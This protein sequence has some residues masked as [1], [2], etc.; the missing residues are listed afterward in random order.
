[1]AP[2]EV[3][4]RRTPR[5]GFTVAEDGGYLVGLTTE[6]TPQLELEGQARELVRR[7]QQLRK[8][9]GLEI[10]DRIRLGLPDL[11]LAA[12]LMSSHRDYV[13]SETLT[14]EVASVTET[15]S[16]PG[17]ASVTFSLG[18][19]EVTIALTVAR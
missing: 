15:L 5:T 12:A 1:M 7:I 8:D 16:D 9:S 17:A 2:G 18:E 10:S 4:L 11:P 6:L 19:E 3:E 14:R 13:V